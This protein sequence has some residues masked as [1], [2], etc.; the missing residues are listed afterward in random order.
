V[1]GAHR[2]PEVVQY[3]GEG[4]RSW[5]GGK[6][7]SARSSFEWC[8]H[9]DRTATD[10][11]RAL[12]ATE[13][14]MSE[15]AT[16]AQVGAL[17]DFRSGHGDL[18]TAVNY[19]VDTISGLYQ[20]G[21]WGL[22]QKLCSRSDTVHAY[23]LQL[24]GEEQWG[25]AESALREANPT[26]PFT[27]IVSAFLHYRTRRW[28]DVLRFCESAAGAKALTRNDKAEASDQPD[29]MV[30]GLSSLMAGE[31]LCRLGRHEAGIQRLEIAANVSN[32]LVAGWAAYIAAMAYR[33]LGNDKESK[34]LFAVAVSR[35]ADPE[36]TKAADNLSI[37]LETT[38]EDLIDERTDRWD[39]GTERSLE[40]VS[41]EGVASHRAEL[42]AE[43]DRELDGFIGMDEV[44]AQVRRLKA[45]SIA[46]QVKKE[47]GLGT[48]DRSY[49][50]IFTGPPGTGKT[51]L[52]RVIGK[53]YAGLGITRKET[54]CEKK[55]IDF[56]GNVQGDSGLKTLV[57]LEEAMGG[58]LFIDEAYSLV[59]EVGFGQKDAYGQEVLDLLVAEMEN[60]RDE[61]IIVIAG[62]DQD[63]ERL[64]A[65][66]DGLK[67][68]FTRKIEF[69][70]Y[71]PDEIWLIAKQ[72]SKKRGAILDDGIEELLISTVRDVMM[73]RNHKGKT[74]LDTAGNGRFVR[75]LL[76]GSEEEREM[77]LYE[78]CLA[79]GI[80]MADLPNEE[81]LTITRSD[82]E[83]TL[84]RIMKEYL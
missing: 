8:V 55:R 10:A 9:L 70:S 59:Q 28:G 18:L 75:N 19:P 30:Q 29:Y 48:E 76:E 80:T 39:P 72:M 22:T 33:S 27:T 2:N 58:I 25:A 83:V 64:L 36:I 32:S 13:G 68:R 77:R 66:N 3:F 82:V 26:V 31:A 43:A 84:D 34:R 56:I 35:N 1:S 62:Y 44:K 24:I 50:L 61:L 47:R 63:I 16:R 37:R 69:Q 81:L 46:S 20:T 79:R 78:D 14:N 17:W 11:W 41:A 53:M 57:V 42:L 23:V 6:L 49:H 73:T 54:V 12:A 15:P 40:A 5:Q 60:H 52:A 38:T 45:Q 74:I 4:I 65:T 67:S 7:P 71:S 21:M 51:T